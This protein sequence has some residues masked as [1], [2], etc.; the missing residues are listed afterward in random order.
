MSRN[1]K[2]FKDKIKFLNKVEELKAQGVEFPVHEAIR[3]VPEDFTVNSLFVAARSAGYPVNYRRNTWYEV[4]EMT[5][6]G[7]STRLVADIEVITTPVVL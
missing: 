4:N 6:N 5:G 2:K 7:I 3:T 1:I